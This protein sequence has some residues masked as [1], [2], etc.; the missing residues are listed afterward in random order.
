MSGAQRCIA[1]LCS[2]EEIPPLDE[3]SADVS[4]GLTDDLQT[5]IVPIISTCPPRGVNE[6]SVAEFEMGGGPSYLSSI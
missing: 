2:D 4:S 5:D 1:Y 6:E 3:M